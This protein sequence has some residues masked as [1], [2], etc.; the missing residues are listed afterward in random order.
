MK[1]ATGFDVANVSRAA[2]QHLLDMSDSASAGRAADRLFAGVLNASVI[3]LAAIEGR[4]ALKVSL[5]PG[6]QDECDVYYVDAAQLDTS[7]S[8]DKSSIVFVD[9]NGNEVCEKLLFNEINL[10]CRYSDVNLLQIFSFYDFVEHIKVLDADFVEKAI[11]SDGCIMFG[12]DGVFAVE[13]SRDAIGDVFAID[14]SSAAKISGVKFDA[15]AII[16]ARL[17]KRACGNV[18]H[19]I[20]AAEVLAPNKS[21]RFR[22]LCDWHAAELVIMPV[23]FERSN[24]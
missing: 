20:Y 16:D 10:K 9:V 22:A 3:Y 21:V 7:L 14:F 17:L 18:V 2:L 15:E 23:F 6:K 19:S 1:Y 13:A 4:A 24:N 8:E 5:L 11:S 12:P